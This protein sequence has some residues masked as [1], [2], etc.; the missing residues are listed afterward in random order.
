MVPLRRPG[1]LRER[2]HVLVQMYAS[3]SHDELRSRMLAAE[4]LLW[5]V[6][7]LAQ[8]QPAAIGAK[9]DPRM[10]A[11]LADLDAGHAKAWS[12][13]SLCRRVG[14]GRT[15]FLKAFHRAAGDSP[16]RHLES[17][18]MERAAHLLV[19]TDQPILEIARTVGFLDPYHFS[20]VFQRRNGCSPRQY[21]RRSRSVSA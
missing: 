20:R 12:V 8:D 10:L 16:R 15:A 11:L 4:I 17:L 2:L 6:Q 21:R 7:L 13:T 1:Q 19:D 14:M 9:A 5:T 18:R 3:R